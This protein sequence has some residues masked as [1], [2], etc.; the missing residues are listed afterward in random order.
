ME[1][2]TRV[3]GVACWTCSSRNLGRS[4][5]VSCRLQQL[6]YQSVRNRLPKLSTGKLA[7]I[8]GTKTL[9]WWPLYERGPILRSSPY[10]DFGDLQLITL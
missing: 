8:G 10:D 7:Q 2:L 1:V 9:S 6:I 3:R 5:L 4:D